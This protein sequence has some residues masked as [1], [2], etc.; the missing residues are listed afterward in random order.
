MERRSVMKRFDWRV[1]GGILLIVGGIMLLLQGFGIFTFVLG[2]LWMLLFAVAGAAFLVVFLTN[3]DQWWALIPGCAL[4]GLAATVFVEQVLPVDSGEWGGAL[5]MGALSASFW[6]IYMTGRDRWWAI[7]PGGVLLTIAAVIVLSSILG[8]PGTGGVFLLGL[9]ATFGLLAFLPTPQG[10]QKWAL[11]P[12]V[13]LLAIGLLLMF[14]PIFKYVWPV[15][16]ILV[17]LYVILRVFGI[18]RR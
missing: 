4:F 6:L 13:V 2:L 7:I 9:G 14:A 12:A 11:I 1:L 5:F 18:S 16:L 15:A 3:R 8:G 17:G 10:Q